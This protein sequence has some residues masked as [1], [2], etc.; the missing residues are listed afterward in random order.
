MGMGKGGKSAKKNAFPEIGW[1]VALLTYVSY[2]VL[3]GV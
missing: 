3:I 1:L 2:A